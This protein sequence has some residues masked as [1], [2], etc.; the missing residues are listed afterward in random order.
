MLFFRR[1]KFPKSKSTSSEIPKKKFR[2]QVFS[3][4][5]GGLWLKLYEV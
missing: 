1:E 4:A 2:I 5:G 3:E